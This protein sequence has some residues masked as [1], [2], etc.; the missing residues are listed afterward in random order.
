MTEP[1]DDSPAEPEVPADSSAHTTDAKPGVP[2]ALTRPASS[3]LTFTGREGIGPLSDR[4]LA[5]YAVLV[6]AAGFIPVPVLDDLLPRQ[7]VRHMIATILRQAGRRFRLSWVKPLYQGEGCLWGLL[8]MA[9]GLVVGFLLY[10]IRRVIALLKGLR[11][12]SQRL[13]STYLLGHTINRYVALGWFGAASEPRTVMEEAVLLRG[14]FDAALE[15]TNPVVFSS[16]IA[17]ILGG[18]RGLPWAAWRTARA[19]MKRHPD[20]VGPGPHTPEQAPPPDPPEAGPMPTDD[21]QTGTRIDDAAA[22]VQDL[23]EEPAVRSFLVEFDRAVDAEVVRLRAS[24]ASS[25]G[26]APGP[27]PLG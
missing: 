27:P 6:A 13:A 24:R 16:S 23:L 7:I 8:G 12:L 4:A 21:V 20:P 1:R 10:P 2:G 18:L 11:S 5:V 14:A 25:P 9:V 17:A 19:M 15:T 22:K 3:H 26:A